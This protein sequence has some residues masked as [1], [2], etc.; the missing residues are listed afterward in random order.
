VEIE[1]QPL[2]IG[3]KNGGAIPQYHSMSASYSCPNCKGSVPVEEETPGVMA[4]CP[5]CK[6]NFALAATSTQKSLF[7]SPIYWFTLIA[8]SAGIIAGKMV[9]DWSR[10]R[11][12]KP[13]SPAA[14]A[15]I[16]NP[17]QG[18][19]SLEQMVDRLDVAIGQT[20]GAGE[21]REFFK[22]KGKTVTPSVM[23]MFKDSKTSQR[24][25]GN[26]IQALGFARVREKKELEVLWGAL[27]DKAPYVR[28]SAIYSLGRVGLDPG[29]IAPTV[30]AMLDDPDSMVR[31][32]AA[33]NLI[34][35]PEYGRAALP[36]LE[37]LLND[38]VE[39]TKQKVARAIQKIKGTQPM[40]SQGGAK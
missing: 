8:I 3:T 12:Y 2:A 25:R 6:V 15:R 7:S 10:V 36:K 31:R 28:Q 34:K 40:A 22:N 23:A 27:K 16:Q 32:G 5:N 35:F 11:S 9:L 18:S 21:A 29:E 20:E 19:I 30:I 33:D 4:A 37:A 17:D 39:S 14:Q 13:I 24:R 1:I 38:P 26:A